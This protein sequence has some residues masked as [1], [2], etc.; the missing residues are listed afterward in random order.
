M[1]FLILLL[2]AETAAFLR[3]IAL[4]T[5]YPVRIAERHQ[6]VIQMMPE[7]SLL[8]YNCPDNPEILI[9]HLQFLNFAL[10]H[11]NLL[12][13]LGVYLRQ[14]SVLNNPLLIAFSITF[15]IA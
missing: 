14:F 12:L 7:Y 1:L 4:I 2:Q 3:M 10:C 13:M 8:F 6:K 11:F 15:F 5:N 9:L